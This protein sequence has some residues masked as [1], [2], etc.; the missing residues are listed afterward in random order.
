MTTTTGK[1]DEDIVRVVVADGQA[2]VAGA[3]AGVLENN[4]EITVVGRAVTGSEALELVTAQRADV[5]VVDVDIPEHGGLEV[6]R[7]VR[8][9]NAGTQIVLLTDDGEEDVVQRAMD[10]GVNGFLLKDC[11][12]DELA[13]AILRI[14]DG[15]AVLSPEVTKFIL[16]DYRRR[17]PGVSLPGAPDERDLAEPLTNRERDVLSGVSRALSNSEI[18]EE[19]NVTA[20]T[21]KTYVSRLL[22]KLRVR[23]RVALAVWAHQSG[24][25]HAE[26]EDEDSAE[27]V[28]P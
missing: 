20:A 17:T 10:I 23:D 12:E 25:R 15:D 9:D 24:F 8:E 4:D 2:L 19:L 1:V 14:D 5:L 6:A 13:D 28:H 26:I 22:T 18:A 27:P 16:D 11:T 21:V 7:A 3:L